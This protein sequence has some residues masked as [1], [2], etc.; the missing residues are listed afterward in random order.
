[1]FSDLRYEIA[2]QRMRFR[3][4]RSLTLWFGI[5][6]IGFICWAWRDSARK[7]IYLI[8]PAGQFDNFGSGV[9]FTC[10]GYFTD[11]WKLGVL[12][13]DDMFPRERIGEWGEMRLGRPVF[14]RA[15]EG[16]ALEKFGSMRM[17]RGQTPDPVAMKFYSDPKSSV[18]EGRWILFIPHWLFLLMVAISWGGLMVWKARRRKM[19]GGALS[20][21]TRDEMGSFQVSCSLTFLF[22]L[23]G[24]AFIV[25]AWDDSQIYSSVIPLPGDG[26]PYLQSTDGGV[27]YSQA[28]VKPPPPP[29]KPLE[30]ER[31]KCPGEWFPSFRWRSEVL[32]VPRRG[33]VIYSIWLFIPYWLVLAL[34]LVAWSGLMAWRGKRARRDVPVAGPPADIP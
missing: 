20:E 28:I 31:W 10:S 2:S 23:F 24:A 7:D 5:L 21:D 16:T 11:E 3:I 27:L 8:F 18:D 4:S 19:A 30:L 9:S 25:W 22:G 12:D 26:S 6:V 17:V 13:F 33:E 32:T 15:L 14:A 29:T 1:M 34:Y